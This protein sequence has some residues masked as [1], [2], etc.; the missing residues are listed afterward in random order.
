M[1][2]N[3]KNT[4]PEYYRIKVKGRL[5]PKWSDWFDG[6]EIAYEENC[7]LMTG[8]VADQSSLHGLLNR[9]RD[10]NLPLLLVER[11]EETKEKNPLNRLE[12]IS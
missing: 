1:A 10:L 6:M 7:T 12:E 2:K 11:R 3:R 4:Y 8:P 9:I 5:E